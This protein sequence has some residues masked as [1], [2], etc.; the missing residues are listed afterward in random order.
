MY[1]A[2]SVFRRADGATVGHVEAQSSE[3]AVFRLMGGEWGRADFVAL[4]GHDRPLAAEGLTSY[5]YRSPHGFVMIGAHTEAQ[6][7][8]EAARSVTG[9]ADDSRLEIWRPDRLAY[10]MAPSAAW[11]Y[12]SS[13]G[14]AVRSGDPG[15]CLYGFDETFTVQSEAHRAA[16]IREMRDN[17]A[18]VEAYPS[19][20]EPDELAR[21]DAL[22]ST[23]QAAPVAASE[24]A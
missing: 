18:D 12:A 22:I 14:S 13:W 10:V 3:E 15:A 20:Y 7:M 6:A 9:D 17:R 5:R 23:L 8:R 21:I 4:S 24:E 11:I 2:Y 19:R 16:C 1:Q